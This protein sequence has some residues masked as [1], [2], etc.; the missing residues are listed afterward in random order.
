MHRQHRM[1]P[2][3]SIGI[4]LLAMLW[5]P[6][7]ALGQRKEI[8]GYYPS[9]KWK[10]RGKVMTP[11]NIPYEKLTIINYAFFYPLSS[12]ELV[13]R[14]IVGDEIALKGERD[15]QTGAYKAGSSMVDLAHRHGVKVLLSVGGWEDS[16]NFPEVAASQSTRAAFAHS[17]LEIAK[18]YDFDG[19]DIDWEYPGYAEHKGTRDDKHN[20]TTLLQITRDSLNA[21]AKQVGKRM[22]LTAALP[23]G[24]SLLANYDFDKVTGILD[25]LNIMT[26][27]FSGIWDPVS[28]HN[29]PLYSPNETDTL[30]NVDA[31]FSYYT[32]TLSVPP[33]KINLGIPFYGHTFANCTALYGTHAGADTAYFTSEG[34]SFNEIT[35]LKSKFSRIWDSRA[36]VPYLVNQ[37]WK[38]IVSYDDEESVG[39][40]AQYVVDQ[41][42]GGVIIWEITGDFLEDGTTPLLDVI[43]SK[44]KNDN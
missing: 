1:I 28:A 36:K 23:A 13:G 24:V 30:R 14:D 12:G 11:A 29:A 31:T 5:L 3:L 20:F 9:W 6:I 43:V 37:S 25:M 33:S 27:D 15:P 19:M 18:L 26:Y 40:K 35:K 21:Y 39:Y 2:H 41:K 17:C 42:V 22:L 34:S 44:F 4:L 32:R 16:N 8:I 38:V 7:D 10:S